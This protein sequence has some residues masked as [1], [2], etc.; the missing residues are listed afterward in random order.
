MHCGRMRRSPSSPCATGGK[1]EIFCRRTDGDVVWTL[2]GPGRLDP[3]LKDLARNLFDPYRPE[4]HYM[5]RPGS[6]CSA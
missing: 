3:T 6:K 5:R 2:S 1:S 4:L